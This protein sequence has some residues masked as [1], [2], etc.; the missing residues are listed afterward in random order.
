MD[1]PLSFISSTSASE[2]VR[3][4][5]QVYILMLGE[6]VV[7]VLGGLGDC[8]GCWIGLLLEVGRMGF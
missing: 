1:I 6:A 7:R 5:G 2:T 3:A 4:N 8:G